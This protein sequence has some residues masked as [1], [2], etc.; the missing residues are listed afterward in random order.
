MKECEKKT[1]LRCLNCKKENCDMKKITMIL[2]KL[3]LLNYTI[4]SVK[5][6]YEENHISND[7]SAYKVLKERAVKTFLLYDKKPHSK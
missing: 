2:N 1:P 5:N 6:E 3:G 7:S 4:N